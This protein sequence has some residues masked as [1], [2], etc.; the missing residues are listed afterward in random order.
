MGLFEKNDIALWPQCMDKYMN[1]WIA[2]GSK[3]LQNA[4]KI[5]IEKHSAIQTDGN[6]SR[7]CNVSFFKRKL[8]NGDEKSREWL[9]FSPSLGKLFC[10]YCKLQNLSNSQFCTEGY[11]DWKNAATR[12]VQHEM[13]ESH[14]QARRPFLTRLDQRSILEC[15]LRKQIDDEK[16][17]W[18][19][20]LKRL[21]AV[22]VHLCIRG[23]PFRGDNEILGSP[24]NGVYLGSL[25]LIATFDS[26]LRTHIQKHGN[27]G[28]GNTSY[29]SSKICNELREILARRV[30]EEIINRIKVSKY[31]SISLDSTVDE[32][33]VDQ[34]VIVF[35]YI[36]RNGD[37]VER[38]LTFLPNQCHKGIEMF[39]G[40]TN[41]LEKNNLRIQDCRGQ[42]YDNA[43]PMSGKF[44]GLQSRVKGVNKFA[45]WV[46]CFGHSL[47]LIGTDAMNSCPESKSFFSFLEQI[48]TFFTYSTER[49]AN[50]CEAL[51][52]ASEQLPQRERILIP[53]RV[54]TTRWSSRADAIRALIKGYSQIKNVLF[55][56]S[57]SNSEA[58]GLYKA[59]NKLETGI[60]IVMWDHLLG[61]INRACQ[62]LQNQT[63]DFN[64]SH[65]LLKSLVAV[66]KNHRESFDYFENQAKQLTG[67]DEYTESQKR[68]CRPNVRIPWIMA[69]R[70][71]LHY[72]SEKIFI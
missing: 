36:E 14:S 30:F 7:K 1:F 6:V 12:L 61:Q 65:E 23:K 31:Y 37:P 21:I 67:T 18:R 11:Y 33:H 44:Q 10:F 68:K 40:L 51:Q 17:Y 70:R 4:D 5:S 58:L 25:E 60:Y 41:I 46:P 52:S 69:K 45:A 59:M 50:L 26:F 53:K 63:S 47:N 42:S 32:S 19:E 49:Y 66:I 38:F 57:D 28:R 3:S 8:K 15:Q 35:R 13:S 20:I 55:G 62:K 43:S 39:Q 54:S 64:T 2:R 48:Y 27:A 56:F 29:L 24:H 22:I 9:C 72:R 16:H 34:L 71:P